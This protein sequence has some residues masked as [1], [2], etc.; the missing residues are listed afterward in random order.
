MRVCT[1]SLRNRGAHAE[2]Y[3]INPHYADGSDAVC[4]SKSLIVA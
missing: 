2:V 3:A 4:G 1:L